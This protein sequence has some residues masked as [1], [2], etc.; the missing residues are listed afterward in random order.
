MG[1]RCFILGTKIRSQ[2]LGCMLNVPIHKR[3]Q[4]HGLSLRRHIN[5]T[6]SNQDLPGYGYCWVFDLP[7]AEATNEFA[8]QWDPFL[9][10]FSQLSGGKLMTFNP[11]H[12]ERDTNKK[13]VLWV[14]ISLPTHLIL[15]TAVMD[16]T[17]S[18]QSLLLNNPQSFR[19][20][21]QLK[22]GSK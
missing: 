17:M 21:P 3:P 22:T 8:W 20:W 13:N 19:I 5:K 18:L 16:W 1:T 9:E 14:W 11:F 4:Q 12:H 6:F 7:G 10:R 15:A 2:P